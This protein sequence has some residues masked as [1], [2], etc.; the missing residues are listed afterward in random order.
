M[1][2][3]PVNP[4]CPAAVLAA[5]WSPMGP[6]N[7]ITEIRRRV[8]EE[9]GTLRKE[10]ALRVALCH[11]TP[12]AT[13]MSSLG[14]Q[15]MYRE[16]HRHAGASAERAFLPENPEDARN[17]RAPVLTYESEM[18]I[19]DCPVVA[20]SIAYELELPGIFEML[21][22]SGMPLLRQERTEKHPLVIA[23]GPLTYSNP[24]ILYPFV[25]LVILGEGEELIH[26][27]LDAA[28]TM[29]RAEL[30]SLSPALR[31][32][33]SRVCLPEQ[34]KWRGLG[35]TCFPHILRFSPKTPSSHRC[36]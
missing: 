16:I 20:F 24:A 26:S 5:R 11:P 27:F 35:M 17:N 31:G 2:E 6:W 34:L 7:V 30:L 23:G 10:A 28:A 15:T 4:E 8:G 29:G 13:A 14:F 18:P 19:S 1:P 33:M 22:L 21:D 36:F 3:A 25:D 32:V 12:Y 9:E